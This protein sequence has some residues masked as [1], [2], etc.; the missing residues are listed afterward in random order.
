MGCRSHWIHPSC[1]G[2]CSDCQTGSAI[3]PIEAMKN[4][5]C[6]QV[7]KKIHKRQSDRSPLSI[8]QSQIAKRLQDSVGFKEGKENSSSVDGKRLRKPTTPPSLTPIIKP[9]EVPAPKPASVTIDYNTKKRKLSLSK[10]EPVAKKPRKVSTA[11]GGTPK[12]YA[13]AEPHSVKKGR[14]KKVVEVKMAEDGTHNPDRLLYHVRNNQPI[15]SGEVEEE[16]SYDWLND[17]S[18]KQ[19]DDF[20]DLNEGEKAFFKLWNTHLHNNPCYGDIMMI[21]ILDMFISEYGVRIYRKNLYKNFMLHLSNFHQ[22]GII[23]SSVMMSM[24]TKFQNII[25]DMLER[26]EEYP[27]TPE[28][29]PIE[30]PYYQPKPVN[31]DESLNLHL[32]S[33]DEEEF[34]KTS[35]VAF[36][37]PTPVLIPFKKQSFWLKK[38]FRNP[39]MKS[40]QE[41]DDT[42]LWPRKKAE[43]KF[44]SEIFVDEITDLNEKPGSNFSF[45]HDVA[46][47]YKLI[48]PRQRRRKS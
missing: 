36:K 30:N 16:E 26:P 3:T 41:E 29:V 47:L 15:S 43:V 48:S 40:Q 32:S 5:F 24:I 4:S 44:T 28:K 42:D 17:L 6:T 21:K 2:L 46:D 23:S 38:S 18:Q 31:L 11:P 19:T 33:E 25:K 1:G 45:T 13:S 8:K 12:K 14:I 7:D 9:P 34:A 27:E 20:V 10:V 37:K 22:F 39:V 35:S